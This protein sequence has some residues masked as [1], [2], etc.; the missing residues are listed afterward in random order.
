MMVVGSSAVYL[1]NKSE[2]ADMIAKSSV[3]LGI[4]FG[5][6]SLAS[7]TFWMKA[8]WG[9]D[10]VSRF[11][12][13]MRLATTLG[14]WLL[15]IAYFIYRRQPEMEAVRINSAVLGLSGIIM[16]PLSYLSSRYL[17]SHHP[18][19]VGTEDQGSLDPSLRIGLYIGLLGLFLIYVFLFIIR[20]KIE[21]VEKEIFEAKMEKI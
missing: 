14:M 16:V 3:E 13:D 21:E 17:R 5:F 8:E 10:I 7:G 1:Y 9:G 15:Y 6:M 18:V 19:I 11:L 12:T 20:I 4:V 2:H